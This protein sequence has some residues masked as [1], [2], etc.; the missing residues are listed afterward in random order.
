MPWTRIC[1]VADL[2]ES[3]ARSFEV[4]GT[5]VLV[6]RIGERFLA[7][8]PVCAYAPRFLCG[9]GSEE[10]FDGDGPLCNVHLAQEGGREGESHG[11]SDSPIPAYA[12]RIANGDVF[13]DL[14]SR[15][16]TEFE[17]ITCSPVLQGGEVQALRFSL[18]SKDGDRRE[19]IVYGRQA[20]D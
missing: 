14:Q 3:C 6:L 18:W 12:T 5:E 8:P 13:L 1:A 20:E 15:H 11:I 2:E 7:I 16:L 9:R 17:R 4:A 10:C 19:A